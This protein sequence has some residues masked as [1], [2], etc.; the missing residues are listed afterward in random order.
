MAAH[1]P[2]LFP[3]SNQ[4]ASHVSEGSRR[5]A[6]EEHD[7][8]SRGPAHAVGVTQLCR[9][10]AAEDL[11]A[12]GSVGQPQAVSRCM[13][14]LASIAVDGRRNLGLEALRRQPSVERRAH[15]PVL[16]PFVLPFLPRDSERLDG[17]LPYRTAFHGLD[18]RGRARAPVST[19]THWP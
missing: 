10:L 4:T 18:T 13:R 17:L 7:I 6:V 5:P 19:M 14:S 12:G 1:T 15:R 16:G 8:T 9:K 3:Q 2:C 11:E